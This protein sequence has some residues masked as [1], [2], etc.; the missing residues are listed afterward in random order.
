MSNNN[1]PTTKEKL[2]GTYKE[3]AGTLKESAGKTFHK[4]ELAAEGNMQKKEGYALKHPDAS[5][6][7]ESCNSASTKR[8]TCTDPTCASASCLTHGATICTNK[9]CTSKDCRTHNVNNFNAVCTEPGCRSAACPIHG[10][11]ATIGAVPVAPP[12]PPALGTTMSPLEAYPTAAYPASTYATG[13]TREADYER[14]HVRGKEFIPTDRPEDMPIATDA[15]SIDSTSSAYVAPTASTSSVAARTAVYTSSAPSTTPH[16]SEPFEQRHLRGQEYI[17]T[18]RRQDMPIATD[19]KS[20]ESTYV[21]PSASTTATA[22]TG[23]TAREPTT[24]DKIKGGLREAAGAIKESTGKTFHNARMEQE[25]H[26][27]RLEGK[28]EKGEYDVTRNP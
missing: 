5:I 15:K 23:Y 10:A 22:A 13:T 14:R 24:G 6:Q 18:D 3:V 2:A 19:A 25:G 20:V 26:Q 7:Y 16:V 1:E 12:A 9:E 27:R 28:A 11:S 8:G 4:P 21:A 17:P